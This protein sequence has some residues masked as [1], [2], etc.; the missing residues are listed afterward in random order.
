MFPLTFKISFKL[1]GKV[2]SDF[3][4]LSTDIAAKNFFDQSQSAEDNKLP[5]LKIQPVTRKGLSI[6]LYGPYSMS[7][8]ENLNFK[9]LKMGTNNFTWK[10]S[11]SFGFSGGIGI[12]YFLNNHMAM[13]TGIEFNKFESNYA[14]KGTFQ[15]AK[16]SL[17]VNSN[18]F[19]K[20]IEAN[21][22]SLVSVNFLT[23]PLLFNYTTGTPGKFGFY[24][25]AGPQFSYAV[26]ANSTA[27]GDYKYS[28]YY[29]YNPAVI[30]YLS[31]P[32]LGF[33]TDD[34]INRKGSADISKINFSIYGSVGIN[35]PIGYFT[36]I[37]IGPEI[38]I[39]LSDIQQKNKEYIDI[40]GNKFDHQSTKVKKYGMRIGIVYKL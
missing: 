18:N 28:G 21:Y 13:K 23:L 29:P 14:L 26:T 35:I 40:F 24:F 17:D 16:L 5:E 36:S 11:P 1:S 6:V 8:I 7:N 4:I 37:Q 25:E 39:G 3:K 12:Y 20:I 31:I 19:N 22:D 30:Q 2:F 32:E 33:Y 34:N 27:T 38:I 10:S 15:D 9:S